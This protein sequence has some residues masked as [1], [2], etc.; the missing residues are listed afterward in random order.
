MDYGARLYSPLLARFISPD[1]IVPDKKNVLDFNRYAYVRHNPMRYTDPTGHEPKTDNCSYAG[2]DCGPVYD[3][4]QAGMHAPVANLIAPVV[5]SFLMP[6]LINLIRRGSVAFKGIR[7]SSQVQEIILR[8]T[9]PSASLEKTFDGRLGPNMGFQLS[10]GVQGNNPLSYFSFNL[11]ISNS[12]LVLDTLS[13]EIAGVEYALGPQEFSLTLSNPFNVELPGGYAVT[14]DIVPIAAVM[15]EGRLRDA[16]GTS[17]T[18]SGDRLSASGLYDLSVNVG[19][20]YI[21]LHDPVIRSMPV[22]R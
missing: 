12:R 18:I 16:K 9:L 3:L 17:T 1:P 14:T 21:P 8:A 2:V 7:Q 22:M 13:W 15:F 4:I 11:A 19:V 6:T 10:M 5:R 20:L